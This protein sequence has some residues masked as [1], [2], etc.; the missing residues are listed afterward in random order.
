MLR[1]V[2]K[3]C[4]LGLFLAFIVLTLIF[5]S[6]HMVPGDPAE[7]ILTGEGGGAASPEAL[8]KVRTELGLDQSLWTQ[9]VNYLSGIVSG[10][11]GS[12]FRD[13]SAV[14]AA[15]A[16][17]LPRTL[18][19]VAVAVLLALVI[20]IPLGSLA[21]RR[22]GVIDAAINLVT[23]TGI[24]VPVYVIGTVLVLVFSL[25][26][27]WFP[28]GGYRAAEADFAGHLQRVLLPALAL[29]FGIISVVSRMTRS[30]VLEVIGQDYVRTAKA[31][32]LS[33]PTVF[34]KHVLRGSLNPVVTVVGLQVGTLLG[35]TVL[36]ERIFNW[37][38]LSGLLVE[39]VLQ[40]DYPVVQGIVIVISVIFILIN[41]IV[42]IS[43]GM[44]DPRVRT[45]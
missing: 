27:G 29:S 21:A 12:S 24:S 11:L 34:R 14:T 2:L 25:K 22:G 44:L 18:E 6:L 32:G 15:V 43:Y 23:S 1:F 20:G 5:L 35:S 19:L 4:L 13:N 45:S 7:I 37:P 26:L 41:I 30:A 17:R 8:A 31:I 10:D 16:E 9:Y 36:V 3:R 39:A 40:R 42:D 38:G 28:A 33:R